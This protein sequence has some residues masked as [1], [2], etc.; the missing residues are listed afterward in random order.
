MVKR[1]LWLF[2]I[3]GKLLY[4]SYCIFNWYFTKTFRRLN[5][6][7]I[8]QTRPSYRN[9]MDDVGGSLKQ[10]IRELLKTEGRPR[11]VFDNFDFKILA[12][13]ILP[14]HR[15]SDMHWI[16]HFPINLRPKPSDH[17][18]N[19]KPLVSD[20]KLFG[21]K[22]Y[23]LDDEEIGKIKADF[24][25]LVRESSCNSFPVWKMWRMKSFNIFRTGILFI[26]LFVLLSDIQNN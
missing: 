19:T 20:M 14:N 3:Y 9:L 17:L 25:I 24:S 7:G 1:V 21:N 16:A 15:N 13:I 6:L 18:D 2:T 26:F 4:Y 10:D 22:E 5:K 12:N 11:I 23:L 8:C